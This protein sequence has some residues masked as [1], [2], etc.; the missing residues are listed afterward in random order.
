MLLKNIN[1]KTFE[2]D[3]ILNKRDNKNNFKNILIPQ[4]SFRITLFGKKEPENRKYLKVNKLYSQ[5]IRDKPTELE[6]DF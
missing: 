3:F 5:N 2:E 4:I 1:N 6:S